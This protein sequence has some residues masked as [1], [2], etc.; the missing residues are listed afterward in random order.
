M[1]NMTDEFMVTQGNERKPSSWL[2][3]AHA[4]LLLLLM[5]VLPNK[6]IPI[7]C[8]QI[9]VNNVNSGLYLEI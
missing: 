8:H 1:K 6:L 9:R 2:S 7:K 3:I 4:L 5:R